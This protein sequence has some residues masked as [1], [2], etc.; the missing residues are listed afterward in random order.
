METEAPSDIL[1]ECLALA[2]LRFRP[3]GKHFMEP[4]DYDKILLCKILDFVRYMGLLAE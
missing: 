2:G 1:C 4:S 3:L